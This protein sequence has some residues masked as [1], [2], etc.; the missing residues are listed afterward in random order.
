MATTHTTDYSNS[1]KRAMTTLSSVPAMPNRTTELATN[2]CTL[3]DGRT[4]AYTTSGAP[5]GVPALAHHGTPGSRLFAG[6]LADVA[7]VTGV[8][9]IVPDRPGYGRSTPPPSGWTWL[10]WRDDV[11]DLLAS[12]SIDHAPSMGFSGGGPFALATANSDRTT[13]IGLVSTVVP[14][15]ENGLAALST[16][17]VVLR[18]LFRLFDAVA[19]VRGPDAVVQQY[20]ARSVSEP[21][22]TA[23]AADFHEALRQGPHAV[24]RETRLFA[25]TSLESIDLDTQLRAWHGTRDENTP[26][27]AI[28]SFMQ[29][30]KGTVRTTDSDHLGTLL[31]CQ[32]NV[33]EWLVE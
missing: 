27:S 4:L 26:L 22:A 32:R 9:L 28:Q 18:T 3:S 8:R 24:V 20:T 10:D 11:N 29:E 17:P 15:A 33:F 2:E 12:E 21:V 30:D 23:V 7:A 31:D 6:L 13:R 19:R 14:P 25:N 1:T 5:D 16:V